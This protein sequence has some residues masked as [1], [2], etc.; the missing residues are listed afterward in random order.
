MVTTPLVDSSKFLA[1][2]PTENPK[3]TPQSSLVII[4]ELKKVQNWTRN[5]NHK[6]EGISNLLLHFSYTLRYRLLSL[7]SYC[8][9]H[10]HHAKNPT[11][12]NTFFCHELR[13]LKLN[14]QLWLFKNTFSFHL[15]LVSCLIWLYMKIL[16]LNCYTFMNKMKQNYKVISKPKTF[17][18]KESFM[19][20]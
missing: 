7:C 16:P 11:C 13:P 17:H 19:I 6:A 14:I 15:L 18:S 9:T 8:F 2:P 3:F 1:P 10:K 5:L 12:Q 20:E 4:T